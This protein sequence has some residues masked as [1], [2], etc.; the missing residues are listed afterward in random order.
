MLWEWVRMSDPDAGTFG[1]SVPIVGLILSVMV[2]L[3]LN[4]PL[5]LLCV[6]LTALLCLLQSL[7]RGRALW[8]AFGCFYIAIPTLMIIWLRGSE[9]GFASEGLRHLL[10]FILVVVAADTFA[11]FGGSYFKGPKMA[12]TLSPNKSWS[13][14]FSGMLG[15][16]IVGALCAKVFGFGVLFGAL[17]AV[18][19]SIVSVFGDFLESGLKRK[20]GVKDAGELLPGHGGLLDRLDSLMMVVFIFGLAIMIFPNF[21]GG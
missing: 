11:Y 3:Y 6:A 4:G 13:G 19:V 7:P 18:P 5:A 12:P 17:L 1:M 2:L 16:C 10:Y 20:L 21:W 9:I 15:A 8:T 14:F